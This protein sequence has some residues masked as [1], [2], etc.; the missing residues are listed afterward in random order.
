LRVETLVD[1]SLHKAMQYEED[2][3]G[4]DQQ[5]GRYENPGA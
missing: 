2:D 4:G 5:G 3:D 1:L